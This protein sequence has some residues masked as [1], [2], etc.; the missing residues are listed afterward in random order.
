VSGETFVRLSEVRMEGVGKRY[1]R[2]W[3]ARDISIS[4][5]PGE[6]YTFLGPPGAGKTTLLKMLAGLVAADAGHI[7]VDDEVIDPVP[8]GKRN[9]GMVF[10]PYGLWPHLSV[11]DNAGFGLR[12][13]GEPRDDVDRKVK[14]ALELVGLQGVE[15]RHPPELSP[16]EQLR[17]AL[18]RV[19][20]M[21]PRLLLLDEPLTG[22]DAAESAAMRQ[23]L[24]RLQR[25]AG[26]TT[27]HATG[28]HADA[29]ALSTR[30]AVLRAGS[31]LQE[32]KPQEI[33]WRPRSRFVAEFVGA[34]NLIP[35]RVVELREVGVVVETAGGTQ[36]PV[37]SGGQPWTIG[38]QGLLCLRPEALVVE[39]S[40][41]AQLGIPGTVAAQSFEGSRQ[42]YEIDIA[43]G[44][45]RVEMVTSTRY[46]GDF[47]AGDRIKVEV[48]PETA[49]LL[50][51]PGPGPRN[52]L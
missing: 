22:L 48:S 40:A 34:A 15:N 52:G 32:G 10:R 30:I 7:V 39:E 2:A 49:V 19:L 43:G 38:A 21:R 16:S 35:V 14:A 9:I 6:F 11:L 50:P 41:L 12:T 28:D 18:A 17:L 3:A 4:I 42:L 26:I 47:K 44:T 5:R 33:Y 45:L 37:A 25:D 27:I 20:V 31:I 36:V 23:L 24:S 51:D 8:A 29:L 46:G 1:G 13:R